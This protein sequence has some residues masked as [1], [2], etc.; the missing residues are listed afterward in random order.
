MMLKNKNI[1]AIW[2]ALNGFKV[3]KCIFNKVTILI[4][5][6]TQNLTQFDLLNLEELLKIK[7]LLELNYLMV[8]Q[9]D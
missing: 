6:L 8:K 9:L 3:G 1:Y 2:S 7:K 5:I 4:L